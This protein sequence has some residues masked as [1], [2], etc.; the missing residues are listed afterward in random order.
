MR[1]KIEKLS[2]V[3]GGLWSVSTR[4]R[5]LSEIFNMAK[6]EPPFSEEGLCGFAYL[7]EGL[8]DELDQIKDLVEYGESPT[9]VAEETE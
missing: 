7:L 4:V 9:D 2:D 3:P 8:A 6:S 1:C 5:S